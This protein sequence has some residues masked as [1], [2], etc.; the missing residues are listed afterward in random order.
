MSGMFFEISS[1][2]TVFLVQSSLKNH[3]VKNRNYVILIIER[4]FPWAINI[5]PPDAYSFPKRKSARF[6]M[7]IPSYK[8]FSCLVLAIKTLG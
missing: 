1:L 6:I 8:Y 5:L 4:R 3:F 7:L 2:W